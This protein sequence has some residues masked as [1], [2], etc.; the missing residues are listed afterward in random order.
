M[1]DFA[2]GARFEPFLHKACAVFYKYARSEYRWSLREDMEDAWQAAVTDVFVEKPHNFRL[3]E[4]GAASPGEFEG[5]LGRYLGK[6]AAN[7]LATRLRSVGKGMQRV[8]SFEEML[9]RC[10]DLDRFMHETGHT[11][12]AADEEAERLAMR[13]VL[14]TCL[15]KLSARV[16]ETFKLALLGY[17][18]VEIQAMTSSGSASAIRRRVSEAKMLVVA[19]VRNK[20]G[21]GHDRGT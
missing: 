5:A 12:P 20:W 19:C 8:Q 15:A 18:D 21:G 4:E 2:D 6:V 14:D 1:R 3:S 16:R 9:A 11:A 13:R 7:K 17:S 10:P